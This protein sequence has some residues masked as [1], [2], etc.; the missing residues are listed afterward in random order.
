MYGFLTAHGARGPLARRRRGCAGVFR[1]R[2]LLFNET[3][4]QYD[5]TA[6]STALRY[7]LRNTWNGINEAIT[8]YAPNIGRSQKLIEDGR[9]R[10]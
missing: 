7:I 2:A 8:K 10:P 6:D 1:K 9:Q 4:L 5:T 3:C